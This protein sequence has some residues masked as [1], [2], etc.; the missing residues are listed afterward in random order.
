M[1][2]TLDTSLWQR[3]KEIIDDAV[4][5]PRGEREVFVREHCTNP[6]IEAE[7]L[8]LL[9]EY[10]EA[11]D[12]LE[13]PLAAE[14]GDDI[15]L[16]PGTQVGPYVIVRYLGRGG[17]GEVFLG[18]DPRLQR[19]V[20]LKCLNRHSPSR[21]RLAR[22][23]EEARAAARVNHPNV[24]A[25]Y[26]VEEYAGRAFIVMEFVEGESLAARLR[27]GMF[28]PAH[29]QALGRQLAAALMAAHGKGVVHRD[30]KPANIHLT[31][32]GSVKVLDFG[33]AT[34]SSE[35]VTTTSERLVVGD[36]YGGVVQPG[37]PAYMSPEQLHGANVDHRSDIYSLGVVLFEM[38]TGERPGRAPGTVRDV[39]VSAL[40]SAPRLVSVITRAMEIDP[41]RRFQTADEFGLA[42]TDAPARDIS[43]RLV[44]ATAVLL[45]AIL[46]ATYVL[47]RSSPP[48]KPH[49]PVAVLIADLQN[50]TNDPAFDRT[51][52]PVLRRALEGASFISALDRN[53]ISTL[54]IRVPPS[55]RLDEAA[56]DELAAKHGLAV[57]LSGAVDRHRNGYRISIKAAQARSGI[58]ITNIQGE[59]SSKEQVIGTATSLMAKTRTAL[60]DA[61]PESAQMFA[62]ANLSA[63]SLEVARH[64]A[65]ALEATSTGQYEEGLRRAATVVRLDPTFGV[66]YQLMAS[67]SY[68]LGRLQDA[69]NYSKE[70][71]RYPSTER[72][73]YAARGSYYRMTGDYQQC[74]KEYGELLARYPADASASNARAL[75][76]LR[77]RDVRGALKE[78][79]KAM[80]ILPTHPVYRANVGL[81]AAYAGDFDTAEQVVRAIQDPPGVVLQSLPLSLIGQGR[82]HEAVQTYEKMATMGVFAAS[83]ATSGLGDVALYE[84]RFSDAVQIF[85][86]GAAANLSAKNAVNAALKFAALAYVHLA[87]R[88]P[89]AAVATADKALSNSNAIPVLVLAG[90]VLAEA[91]AVAKAEVVAAGLTSERSTLTQAYGKIIEGEITL[92]NGKP[93]DAIRILTEANSLVDTWE[94]HFDLGRAYLEAGAF[95]QA[96]FE[97][98]RCVDRRGEA[99]MLTDEDPTYGQ[100]P[101][102]YYYQGRSREGLNAGL[103]KSITARLFGRTAAASYRAYLDIR[104]KSNEDPLVPEIRRRAGR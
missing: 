13:A 2:D 77:L 54:Q 41:D 46:A 85:E 72:E 16:P 91:G 22:V 66:A 101:M 25:I 11:P 95:P 59:A 45:I 78:M 80:Q 90:R 38:A 76:L 93:H 52:E 31:P 79:R 6:T 9:R 4:N 33:V 15:D 99:L 29:V 5:L 74:A 3:A 96:D 81:M 60:G 42:L 36:E 10:D 55:K 27:R 7:V 30:L 75:C 26:D 34:A 51:L 53:R 40:A 62:M 32:A 24:A 89:A 47:A 86:R 104:G 39:L 83:F 82:L 103:A 23:L 17:M 102:V 73:W 94:G 87:R 56:A 65:A 37:T 57:V 97:F 44:A 21:D 12:F 8:S 84:G 58:E 88:Q 64:Y 98:D 43:R 68:N 69:E 71:F 67:M 14:F 100:F 19:P 63:T 70:A 48:L 50:R 49:E 1:T 20:A 92:K 61:T 18:N 28:P 35:S